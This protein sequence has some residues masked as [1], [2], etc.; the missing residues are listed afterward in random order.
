MRLHQLHEQWHRTAADYGDPDDFVTSLNAALV[1]LR[2][3]PDMLDKEQRHVPDF[4]A[5]YAPHGSAFRADPLLRWLVKAR[6][7]VVHHGDLKLH[8]R[9]RVRVLISGQ[10]LPEIDL[11][12]PP[13]L[14]QDEI[15]S[16]IA[17]RL[18]ARVREQGVL[19][20]ERRW[21]AANLPDQ[22]LLEVLAHGYGKV[23]EVVADAHRQAGVVMQTFG[24][25]AHT[26]RPERREHLGGRLSCMV[27]HAGLRTA[28]V[29]L[30]RE[31]LMVPESR[32][33]ELRREELEGF[34][35]GFTIPEDALGREEGE[36]ILAAGERM[37]SFA[38]AL[39]E[40]TGVH[41]PMA[42]I[43]ET[44]E[45]APVIV[46]LRASD[47]QEQTLMVETIVEEVKRLGAE[48]VIFISELDPPH[49]RGGELVVAALTDDGG[50][51]V[52]HT[53]IKR[54]APR[55]VRLGET[56]VDERLPDFL[57]PVQ[58]A[59]ANTA[60]GPALA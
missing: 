28:Y 33:R 1:S 32:E 49:G 16:L 38:R 50:R 55:A 59:L 30:A 42:M 46:N 26:R 31:R 25:E 29:H 19:A 7:H 60:G 9:A 14:D 13:L 44:S 47:A 51:R 3:I 23:A 40:H 34:D 24:D 17:P 52:W 22:E 37:V 35:P 56:V 57:R 18:S 41:Y 48:G 53:P 43:H 2:S 54:T 20:V 21:V 8:S 5:W 45:L 58:R 4:E 12:M 36:T 39:I 11:D 10:E 27:A 6:N 15:A